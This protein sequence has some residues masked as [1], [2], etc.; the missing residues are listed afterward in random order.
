MTSS[1]IVVADAVVGELNGH[2]FSLSFAAERKWAPARR[3]E[4][5][6]GLAVFVIP[7]SVK[8]SPQGRRQ[9]AQEI[10]VAVV[11]QAPAQFDECAALL[12]EITHYLF[13]KRLAGAVK[14][15]YVES[16]LDLVVHDQIRDLG[17]YTGALSLVYRVTLEG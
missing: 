2:A 6:S 1:A 13:E 14:A 17:V 9:L 11:V 7:G 16:K 10:T 4:E 3:R 15:T 8:L 12:E 5:I